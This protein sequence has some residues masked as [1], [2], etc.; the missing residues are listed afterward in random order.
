MSALHWK[1]I[2]VLGSIPRFDLPVLA[3]AAL[4][5]AG[6]LA[7]ARSTVP[8]ARPVRAF[9][10]AV[11]LTLPAGWA[12]RERGGVY[13]AR[14]ASLDGLGPSLVVRSVPP[15]A[16]PEPE[17]GVGGAGFVGAVEPDPAHDAAIA[18]ETALARMEEERRQSGVG[19]RILDAEEKNAFGGHP[20]TWSHYAIVREPP[21]TTP[22]AAV[23]PIV[24]RGVDVLV[25]RR[26]GGLWQVSAEAVAAPGGALDEELVRALEDLR[27]SR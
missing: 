18:F 13:T 10:G 16:R 24:V 23:V 21:G 12:G 2:R 17:E 25:R 4:L 26:D 1:G 8:A 14:R 3:V 27:V 19:H 9:G 7:Y 5:L 11:Q 20:S 15:P 6:G 22:G